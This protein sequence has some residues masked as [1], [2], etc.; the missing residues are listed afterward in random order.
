MLAAARPEARITLVES[1]SRKCEFL[2]TAARR[3][4]LQNVEVAWTRAEEWQSGLGRCDV[5]CA[6]ALAA[7]PVLAEYA[8][9][10]LV[11]DGV[12]I[13]WKGAVS[14]EEAADG[15]AAAAQLGLVV[16]PVRPVTP[17]RGSERRTLHVLRKVAPTPPEFPRRPG[18][19][20]KRPLSAK[21]VR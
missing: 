2:R 16:E 5:V 19:A 6:R 21:K 10:L 9:P 20:T 1:V 8:A 17:F 4:D 11:Q 12:L 18:M 14:P 15:I 7:L 13:A 3:M